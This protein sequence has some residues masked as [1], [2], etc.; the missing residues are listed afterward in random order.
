MGP[1][2]YKKKKVSY[3]IFYDYDF[4][5]PSSFSFIIFENKHENIGVEFIK[6]NTF[7]RIIWHVWI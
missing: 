3:S 1:L 2:K 7:K 5:A 6:K 4:N